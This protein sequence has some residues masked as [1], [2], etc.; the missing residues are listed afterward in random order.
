MSLPDNVPVEK[1]KPIGSFKKPKQDNRYPP[2]ND[3]RYPPSDSR[4]PAKNSN[5]NY[6]TGFVLLDIFKFEQSR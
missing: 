3:S 6:N 2:A 1:S 5:R 4:Y